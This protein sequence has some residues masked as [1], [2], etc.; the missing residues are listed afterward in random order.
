MK[1]L[2]KQYLIYNSLFMKKWDEKIDKGT[3]EE[4][5]LW[6]IIWKQSRGIWAMMGQSAPICLWHLSCKRGQQ[7]NISKDCKELRLQISRGSDV[8]LGQLQILRYCSDLRLAIQGR[9]SSPLHLSISSFWREMRFHSRSFGRDSKWL[10][11][12]NNKDCNRERG[13]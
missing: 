2:K 7:K 3:P 4:I 11:F 5:I 13:K 12:F 8:R 1:T 6:W 9:E 10:T